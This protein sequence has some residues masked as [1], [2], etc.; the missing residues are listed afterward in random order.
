MA[1]GEQLYNMQNKL[2][3]SCF[4][5]LALPYKENKEFWCKVAGELVNRNISSL[6]ELNLG[7]RSR[8][9]NSL[10]AKGAKVKHNPYIPGKLLFYKKGRFE[11]EGEATDRPLKVSAN[12]AGY[13]SKIHAI[14]ADLKLPW[15]YVDSIAKQKF[16]VDLVE[17]LEPVELRKVTQMMII[18]QKRQKKNGL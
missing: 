12:K 18:H 7:E 10:K 1:N 8:L 6:S 13:V 17:W 3:H 2:I 11:P 5:S 9:L 15:S 16:G 14:L 4:S